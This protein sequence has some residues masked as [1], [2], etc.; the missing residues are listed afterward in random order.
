MGESKVTGSL[1]QTLQVLR[2]QAKEAMSTEA[3]ES[4]QRCI[5]AMRKQADCPKGLLVGDNAPDFILSE[6]WGAQYWLKESLQLGPVVVVFYR[7]TWCTFCE[8]T[9]LAWQRS[10]AEYREHGIGVVA[11]S[12]QYPDATG[13]MVKRLGLEFP[14]LCDP[15]N[16][17]ARKFSVV[18]RQE[19]ALRSIHEQSGVDLQHC[20]KDCSQQL[21]LPGTFAI[22]TNSE[23]L[24]SH[25]DVDYTVRAEPLAVFA[26]LMKR[27]S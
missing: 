12:P 17:V 25:V 22:A 16:R 26:E 19:Q 21:P 9:L 15:G 8:A 11:I 2:L 4:I 14:V 27:G 23:L 6:A 5:A 3:L 7:G 18:Y 13:E 20:N 24:Y 1:K 10:F